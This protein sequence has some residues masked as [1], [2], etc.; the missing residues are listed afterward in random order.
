MPVMKSALPKIL[1]AATIA[2][3]T[4]AQPA[5]A[6]PKTEE[7][8]AR[9]PATLPAPVA[10]RQQG[11]L[12]A[13]RAGDYAALRKQVTDMRRFNF[14]FGEP[15]DPMPSWRE[16]QKQKIDL[17][18]IMAAIFAMPCSVQKVEGKLLYGWPSASDFTWSQLDAA[19]RTALQK[20]YGAKLDSY[21]LEGRAKGYYVGWRGIIAADG[22]WT[23]F[24]AGD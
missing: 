17:A 3:V 13:A 14:D 21:W 8:A 22:T 2:A 6:Q 4:L 20:L 11:I 9:C 18:A 23:S 7:T 15:G 24:V 16:A 12:A 5:V 10:A 1:L 19:E